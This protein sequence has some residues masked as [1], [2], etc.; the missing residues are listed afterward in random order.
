M[1]FLE[2]VDAYL[3]HM[4]SD[5]WSSFEILK[6]SLETSTYLHFIWNLQMNAITGVQANTASRIKNHVRRCR[7]DLGFC[8]GQ[9][10]P[11][12]LLALNNWYT[13]LHWNTSAVL[14]FF[15]PAYTKCA[16]SVVLICLLT[17]TY[18]TLCLRH[19]CGGLTIK[20]WLTKLAPW[21]SG[22]TITEL[23]L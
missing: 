7:A 2:M 12:L 3:V 23:F 9:N 18:Y 15:L 8:S 20:Y 16:L 4:D 10:H 22:H 1:Y 6:Q 19:T 21:T 14:F 17:G 5:M 13:G 11:C